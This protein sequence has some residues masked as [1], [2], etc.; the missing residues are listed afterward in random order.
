MYNCTTMT[1]LI[2]DKFRKVLKTHRYSLTPERKLLFNLLVQQNSPITIQQIVNQTKDIINMST[3]YRNLE[4]FEELGIITRV[5]SGWKF[6]IELSDIFSSHHHHLTCNSC[7]KIV[8]FE[9]SSSLLE[10]LGQLEK[11]YG[12]V[13]SSH[14]LEIRGLCDNCVT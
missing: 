8:S 2:N 10:E 9:E 6:K 4:L 14:S 7:G 3:V 1:N 13:A 12:F 5:Y 11:T